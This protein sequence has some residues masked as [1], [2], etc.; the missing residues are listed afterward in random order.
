M[1][2]SEKSRCQAGNLPDLPVDRERMPSKALHAE[3]QPESCT[4]YTGGTVLPRC[5]FGKYIVLMR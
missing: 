3:Q 5:F 4:L 1:P 2:T